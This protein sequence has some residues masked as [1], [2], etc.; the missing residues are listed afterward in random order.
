MA[1][2]AKRQSAAAQP[3]PKKR[4]DAFGIS[5]RK[6]GPRNKKKTKETLDRWNRRL[7]RRIRSGDGIV[8]P[9]ASENGDVVCGGA[10]S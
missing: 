1:P 8:A 6:A 2:R 3:K 7:G 5:N 10:A 4:R 9:F